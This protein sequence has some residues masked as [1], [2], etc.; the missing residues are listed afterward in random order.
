MFS[1]IRT[2]AVVLVGVAC[3]TQL[4][5]AEKP[6]VKVEIRRAERKPAEGL[7][8]AVVT[9]TTDKVYLHKTVEAANEDIEAARVIT[10]DQDRPAL[11]I[12]FTKEGG[13]KMARVS[14]EHKDR[15]LAILVDGKVIAA[16]NVRARFSERALITGHFTK[17]E[18][19]KIARGIKGP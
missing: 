17:D 18:V 5:A 19:E 9:G 10:D 7:T 2:V 14:G 1:A 16:P 12:V 11:E 8:E 13:K 6:R 4:V 3:A 15:P